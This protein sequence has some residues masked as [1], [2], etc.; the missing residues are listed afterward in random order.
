MTA[1]Q[2]PVWR[3]LL[4]LERVVAR[5]RHLDATLPKSKEA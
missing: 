1:T 3:A 5:I 4:R 2:E